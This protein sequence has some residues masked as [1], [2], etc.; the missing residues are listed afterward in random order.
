V[1]LSS[2]ERKQTN[3]TA[4]HDANEKNGYS[5][6]D[7]KRWERCYQD[8][9][10][11]GADDRHKPRISTVLPVLGES[12]KIGDDVIKKDAERG[13]SDCSAKV[14]GENQDAHNH[15]EGNFGVMG[16]FV[17]GMHSS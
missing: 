8:E 10:A 13:E 2:L 16:N 1:K 17:D 3:K 12:G 5:N 14:D 11:E 15:G 7:A 6:S 9:A 4:A